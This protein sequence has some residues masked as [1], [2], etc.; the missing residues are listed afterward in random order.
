MCKVGNITF[1]QDYARHPTEVDAVLAYA[2]AQHLNHELTVVF[3]PHRVSRTKQYFKEFPNVLQK[4]DNVI[5]FEV[6]CAFE[7]PLNGIWA[8]LSTTGQRV[9]ADFSRMALRISAMSSADIVY[10]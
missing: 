1:I 8:N 2:R 10:H 4:F 9:I 7:E 5:L 3:Q 6:Y